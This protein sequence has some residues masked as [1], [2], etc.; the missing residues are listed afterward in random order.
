MYEDTPQELVHDLFSEAVFGEHPLGRPV[1]GT[2][3][4]DLDRPAAGDRDLPPHDVRA[5]EHRRRRGG[6]PRSTSS[7][8]ALLEARPAEA[9]RSRQ[10]AARPA[11]ARRR[12]RPPACASSARTPS[13]TTS[14]SAR[15]ASRAPTAAASPRRCSTAILGGSASS[16][17]F[18][19]IREKRGMAYAVYSF[20]SQYSDTGLFGVYIGTREENLAACLEIAARADRRHRRGQPA[21]ER[22]RAREGEPE[23][24]D[25]AVDGVD[26]EP[27]EPARQVADHRHGAAV[28]RAD[29]RPR[30]T[31]SSAEGVAELAGAP[32]RTGAALGGRDRA[33]RGALPARR[34]SRVHPGLRRARRRV[35]VALFGAGG[36]VGSVL[37]P[38]ARAGRPRARSTSSSDADAMVDFTAPDAVVGERRARARR[39]AFRASSAR[40]AADLTRARRSSPAS[41]ASPSSSRRTSRSAPC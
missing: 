14:A 12:R 33:E 17:L 22:A 20:A 15:P 26:V 34:S 1:I 2:R 19:E 39:P 36:K 30:S 18:Q 27:H 13:S 31:R 21:A 23:G 10:R 9:R 7:C 5:G 11:A 38:R 29:H 16:R 25:H 24:T 32:A 6:Q 40:P 35:K 28:A 8:C 3:R 4:R 37:A 41:A